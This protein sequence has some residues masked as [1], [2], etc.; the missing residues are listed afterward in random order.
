MKKWLIILCCL[1]GWQGFAE[2]S[3]SEQVKVIRL[4]DYDAEVLQVAGPVVVD[5]YADWCPPCRRMKP[6]VSTLA[7]KYQGKVKFVALNVDKSASLRSRFQLRCIPT[8]LFVKDQQLLEQ[9]DG[10]LTQEQFEEKIH[11]LFGV[12]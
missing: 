7:E 5:F 6:I 1:V 2:G 4:E 9:Q 8:F 11:K 12:S 10:S 3:F